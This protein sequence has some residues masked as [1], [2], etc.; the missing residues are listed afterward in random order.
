MNDLILPDYQGGGIVNLMSTLEHACGGTPL[1]PQ[2]RTPMLPALPDTHTIILLVIDGM[3][4]SCLERYG[5][6]T[7]LAQHLRGTLTSVFPSTTASAITTFLTGV[8]PQQHGITGWHTYLP[9]LDTLLAV[10]PMKRRHD[11]YRFSAAEIG[12]TLFTTSSIF[13]RLAIPSYVVAPQ[14]IID[15]P[16]NNYFSGTATP[17]GYRSTPGLFRA[18]ETILQLDERRK[19]IYAYCPDI[20]KLAHEHGM[21]SGK[22]RACLHNLDAQVRKFLHGN[23]KHSVTL[24]VT[25]DHGLIDADAR[26]W[27]D[28]AAHPVLAA[29]LARPLAG[30]KRVAYCYVKPG[31]TEIFTDYV[32]STLSAYCT[33][34]RS[35]D[36]IAQGYF[37][38]YAPHAELAARSGDFILIMKENFA[39]KDWLPG[40]ERYSHIGIH[41]GLNVQEMLVPLIVMQT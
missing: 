38:H 18:L 29:T 31:M 9:T 26:L 25:A 15:T 10:L 3:G 13:N 35:A 30:E 7:L 23:K 1:Y 11:G 22:V 24:I 12:S 33:L 39:I 37:G 28:V 4:M 36:L 16:F 40:E 2:L 21:A 6:K 41:G 17:R 5:K 32:Q 8:A 20:D 14:H 27:I 19:Y 34:H